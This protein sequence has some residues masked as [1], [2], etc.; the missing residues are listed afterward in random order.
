MVLRS[1]GFEGWKIKLVDS[2]SL[3]RFFDGEGEG[4]RDLND[5]ELGPVENFGIGGRGL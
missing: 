4:G 2:G 3:E 1:S 5:E